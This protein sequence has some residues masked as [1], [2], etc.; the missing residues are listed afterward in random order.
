MDGKTMAIAEIAGS[1]EARS[2]GAGTRLRS[3]RAQAIHREILTAILEHKLPSSTRLP[4]DEIGALYNASRTIVRSALEALWHDGVVTIEPHRGAFVS[5]PTPREAEEV[6]QARMLIEPSLAAR[7]AERIAPADIA[8]LRLHLAE[9]EAANAA[10]DRHRAILLSGAFH[11]LIAEVADQ[12][13]LAGFVRELV[14]RSSLIVALYWRRREVTC[15]SHAHDRL[16][17]ALEARDGEGAASAMLRHIEE[18]L[19][20]LDLD[21]ESRPA[22]ALAEILRPVAG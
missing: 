9:E 14:S 15:D 13:V 1:S 19:S 16:V 21:A 3:A 18:L 8:R 2:G 11:T 7:A 20:G 10:E 5:R 6:F 4:E 17:G 22:P 12:A